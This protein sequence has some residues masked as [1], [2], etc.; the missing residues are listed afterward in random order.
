M[1]GIQS[2]FIQVKLLAWQNAIDNNKGKKTAAEWKKKKSDFD[3]SI[4]DFFF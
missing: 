2:R 3:G 4:R 1:F